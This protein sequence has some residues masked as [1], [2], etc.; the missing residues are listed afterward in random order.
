[1]DIKTMIEK[2]RNKKELTLE[3]IKIFVGKYNSGEITEAQA[4]ALLSYIYTAGLTEDEIIGFAKSMADLGEKISYTDI[5]QEVLNKDSTGGVGDKGTVILLPI[6]AALGIPVAKVS[7]RGMGVTGGTIDKLESIPGYRTDLSVTEFKDKI[8][9]IGVGVINELENLNPTESK[10]YRLRTQIGCG[11]CIPIIAAS[12]LS[13]NLSTGS[14]KIAF[15]ITYGTGSYIKNKEQ[16]RKL[17][18]VLKIVGKKLDKE[19]MCVITNMDEPL[20]YAV[21]HNL[22]IIETINALKGRMSDDLKEVTVAIGSC[23]V[24][25]AT[26]AK[27]PKAGEKLIKTVLEDGSAFNKFVQMVEEQGGNSEYIEN[28]DLFSKAKYIMPVFSTGDGYISQ[29]NSDI[30]GSIAV[31]LGAGRMHDENKIDREAGIVLAKK[32]GD[33]VKSGEIIAYIHTNDESKVVSATKNLEEA[34]K[35]STKKPIQRSR[36]IEII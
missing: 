10:I 18:K 29:I 4:G 5:H 11:D 14:N 17:A 23:M 36:V 1:M 2:K 26:K 12:L 31:Y 6:I 27:N 20:G 35:Y 25:M 34:F 8:Q 21:G 9:K 24:A 30:L 28:P 13:I 7:S 3:E 16:A 15:E 33:A 19:I 22:E 32:I